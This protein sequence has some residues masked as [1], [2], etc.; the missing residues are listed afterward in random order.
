MKNS[1][2]VRGLAAIAVCAL[3]LPVV[4][5]EKNPVERPFKVTGIFTMAP[6]ESGLAG[7]FE[8]VGNATHLGRIVFPG[9]YEITGVDGALV[10]FHIHGTYWAANGDAIEVDC[11]D[12]V[13]E[14]DAD[15]N[16][17]ASMGLVTIIGGTGR[18]ANASGSYLGNIF[19]GDPMPFTALGTITY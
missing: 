11:P 8:V 13:T 17:V 9:T 6:D 3:V 15:G 14:Y 16:A 1:I 19:S 18:F 5:S 2:L 7:T 12:W 4:G 10:Y